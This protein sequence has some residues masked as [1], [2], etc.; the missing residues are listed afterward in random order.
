MIHQK[1]ISEGHMFVC[2][3]LITACWIA[4]ALSSVCL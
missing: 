2:M 4:V 3:M 1:D